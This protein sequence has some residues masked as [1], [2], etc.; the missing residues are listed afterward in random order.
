MA[1]P[2]ACAVSSCRVDGRLRNPQRYSGRM[3][4]WLSIRIIRNEGEATHGPSCVG[5]MAQK[6]CHPWRRA[7][8]RFRQQVAGSLGT[9]GGCR[10]D[11][12]T[13]VPLLV[14]IVHL[15]VAGVG[16][17]GAFQVNS[18]LDGGNIFQFYHFFFVGLLQKYVFCPRKAN[19]F[20]KNRNTNSTNVSIKRVSSQSEE[21]Y[22]A[23]RP[24]ILFVFRGG[25]YRLMVLRRMMGRS[26]RTG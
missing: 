12:R 7:A 17:R 24:D 19:Y 8:G 18:R 20:R 22:P 1:D 13:D 26:G 6:F 21:K 16:R 3:R 9:D 10:S 5:A 2:W 14:E 15:K 11:G 4:V 23:V 25:L